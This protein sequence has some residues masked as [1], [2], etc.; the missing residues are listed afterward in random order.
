LL[1]TVRRFSGNSDFSD[2]LFQ[3]LME[4]VRED[5]HAL[6]AAKANEVAQAVKH[7]S[8]MA[9]LRQMLVQRPAVE[10]VQILIDKV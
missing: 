8:A 9:A 1:S 2:P 3:A 7:R 6:V 4:A 10:R 5:E